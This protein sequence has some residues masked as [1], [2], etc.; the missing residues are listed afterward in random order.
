M[1]AFVLLTLCAASA[2]T[3]PRYAS[4]MHVSH[5]CKAPHI[6]MMASPPSPSTASAPSSARAGARAVKPSTIWELDLYT[7]PVTNDQGKKLWE[8]LVTDAN[9]VMRHVEPLPSSLINSR[10]LRKRINALVERAEVRPTQVRFFRSEMQAM[11]GV[12]LSE[13]QVLTVPTRRTYSLRNWIEERNRDVYPLMPGYKPELAAEER[14]RPALDRQPV[15]MPDALRGDK[16]AFV[17]L[18]LGEMRG[19]DAS[20]DESNIGFGSTFSVEGIDLPDE[21]LVP[22]LL[23]TSQRAEPLAAWMSGT[24]LGAIGVDLERGD[25]CLEVGIDTQYM[26]ARL[27]DLTQR[28]EAA[29]FMRTCRAARGLHFVAVQQS[30]EDNG[31]KGFW[32]LRN[33]DA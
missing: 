7:R 18:P 2:V 4:A 8:L 26:F 24:E 15:K 19:P 10:E 3:T 11:I 30:L 21:T 23:I 5:S 32:L 16:W 27:W 33:Y 29:S 28:E 31:V 12:A 22:G 25:L 1:G 9:G 20:I 13:L 6:S 14:A 17:E